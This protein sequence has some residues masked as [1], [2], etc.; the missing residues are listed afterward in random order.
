MMVVSFGFGSAR[1]MNMSDYCARFDLRR[2]FRF[3]FVMAGLGR[4]L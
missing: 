1:T 4:G 2:H 3:Y